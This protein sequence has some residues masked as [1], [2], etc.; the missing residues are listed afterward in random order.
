M[1][2][3]KNAESQL[4]SDQNSNHTNLP[5]GQFQLPYARHHKPLSI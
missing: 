3:E 5:K 4:I 2:T 1:R